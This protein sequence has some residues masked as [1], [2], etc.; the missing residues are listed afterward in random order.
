MAIDL[1]EALRGADLIYIA[2]PIGATVDLLPTIAS[3]AD[4]DA[5]VTDA[6]STKATIARVAEIIF[7]AALDFSAG[8][9]WPARRSPG[10]ITPMLRF[11]RC[12]LRLDRARKK[13]VIHGWNDSLRSHAG[14]A[15]K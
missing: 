6:C 1:D 8:T 4:P 5:L 13:T 9:P 10:S 3:K 11:S 15:R 2:M 12:A 14:S 7:S